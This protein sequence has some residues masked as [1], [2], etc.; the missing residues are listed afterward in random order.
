MCRYGKS[1]KTRIQI[2]CG[3]DNMKTIHVYKL[4]L[5]IYN[6]DCNSTMVKESH[7]YGDLKISG[8]INKVI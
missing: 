1:L 6:V 8:V 7:N 5:F 3:Y 4:T 2:N